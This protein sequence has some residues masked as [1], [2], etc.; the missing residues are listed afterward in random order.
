ME[1][2]LF[3]P[4]RAWFEE[5]G[6]ACDG[7]VG[8]ID[9]YMEKDGV[10]A[11]VELKTTLDF[12]SVQQAALRQKVTDLVFIGIPRPRDLYTRAF[13]DKLYLLK[14]LGIGLIVVSPRTGEAEIVNAPV[15]SELNTFQQRN[16]SRKDA[17]AAEF[18]HRRLRGNTGGVRGTP[19]MTGYREDALLVLDALHGLGGE[20]PVGRIRDVSGIAKAGSI[21]YNNQYGC[22]ERGAERGCYR[23]RPE[24][25]KALETYRDAVRMLKETKEQ[26]N[27]VPDR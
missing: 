14:R 23:I 17:L 5:R 22:F 10:H 13:R 24:G 9:L 16:R 21:L 3:G 12:R 27:A 8:G 7:E 26:K 11:A 4:I 20:A 15:V 25:E 19:L 6:Y 2:D 18:G 1:K